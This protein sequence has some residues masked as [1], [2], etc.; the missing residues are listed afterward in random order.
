MN[1]FRI[2][3]KEMKGR[4]EERKK[5]EEAVWFCVY[6]VIYSCFPYSGAR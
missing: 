1:I 5:R 4:E 3:H 2:K 6:E